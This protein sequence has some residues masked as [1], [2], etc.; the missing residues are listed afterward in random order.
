MCLCSYLYIIIYTAVF[1]YFSKNLWCIALWIILSGTP[2]GV[3]ENRAIRCHNSPFTEANMLRPNW[4]MGIYCIIVELSFECLVLFIHVRIMSLYCVYI[5]RWAAAWSMSAPFDSNDC[6]WVQLIRHLMPSLRIC[7]SKKSS[8][9]RLED[10]M[11]NPIIL[12]HLIQT[13]QSFM[14]S[15]PLFRFPASLKRG[16]NEEGETTG[17]FPP[18]TSSHDAHCD[19]VVRSTCCFSY[20]FAPVWRISVNQMTMYVQ[21]WFW[22]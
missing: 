4:F 16:A 17:A 12:T 6:N 15:S 14:D 11:D 10:C 9:W 21:I 18:M 7:N 1:Q 5:Y 13:I 22:Q 2:Q 19:T 8:S 3:E 20:L